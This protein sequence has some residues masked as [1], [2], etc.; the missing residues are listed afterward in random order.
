MTSTRSRI[1]IKN[2]IKEGI[3]PS[4]RKIA[5]IDFDG[6]LFA[7][8]DLYANKPPLDGCGTVVKALKQLGFTIVIFTSR[9]SQTWHR[10]EGWDH[11]EAS[12]REYEYVARMLEENSIP[13]DLITAEKMPAQVYIDDRAIGFRGDWAQ[14]TRELEDFLNI[15]LSSKEGIVAN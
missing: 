11:E 5:L 8:G 7:F 10:A 3:P 4:A 13:Y 2:I 12:A 9:M 14:T 6:T 15:N 1:A